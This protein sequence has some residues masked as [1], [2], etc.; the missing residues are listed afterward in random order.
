MRKK[1]KTFDQLISS[2][3]GLPLELSD[4]ASM[5]ARLLGY[6]RAHPLV[7]A[8]K[9]AALPIPSPISREFRF[10]MFRRHYRYVSAALVLTLTL[11]GALSAAAESALPGQ[12]LY[13]IKT[14]INEEVV[15]IV[16]VKAQSKAKWEVKRVTRRMEEAKKLAVDGQLTEEN[17]TTIETKL[18]EHTD[19][20]S[21]Q[22]AELKE[23]NKIAAVAVS[24]E[25]EVAL[26]SG[27]KELSAVAEA[28]G[29]ARVA[30]MAATASS[31][32]AT[33]AV[34]KAEIVKEAIVEAVAAATT[35]TPV[36]LNDKTITATTTAT[37]TDTKIK[38]GDKATTSTTSTEVIRND[39]QNTAAADA[40]SLEVQKQIETRVLESIS[41]GS[42]KINLGF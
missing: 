10:R 5:R 24:T 14:D 30:A 29:E 23:D 15:A 35:T 11:S 41:N 12:A 33:I 40:I 9:P 25:V 2:L 16:S 37:T 39:R 19:K 32:A 36:I 13:P 22:I 4:K 8:D 31:S 20:A 28:T 42:L 27:E 1:T 3:R 7:L 18:K 38:K 17:K 26:L 34:N 6:M 21:E